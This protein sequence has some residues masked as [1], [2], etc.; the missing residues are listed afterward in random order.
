MAES[1]N[2]LLFMNG[3]KRL[4][5]FLCYSKDEMFMIENMSINHLSYRSENSCVFISCLMIFCSLWW[6]AL[7]SGYFVMWMLNKR[8]PSGRIL[9][10]YILLSLHSGVILLLIFSNTI[11]MPQF[12]PS[13]FLLLLSAVADKLRVFSSLGARCLLLPWLRCH[14]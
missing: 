4:R 7:K 14:G 9:N 2:I 13:V 3:G 12:L 11:V 5:V 6:H 8:V 1:I 10:I